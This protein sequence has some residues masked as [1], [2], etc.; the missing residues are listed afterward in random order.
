MPSVRGP[1]LMNNPHPGGGKVRCWRG[2]RLDGLSALACAR[3]PSTVHERFAREQQSTDY[4]RARQQR[5]AHFSRL[6]SAAAKCF[7]VGDAVAERVQALGSCATRARTG[8]GPSACSAWM[9]R[10][11]LP[12]R[13]HGGADCATNHH[14]QPHGEAFPAAQQPPQPPSPAHSGRGTTDDQACGACACASTIQLRASAAAP[15]APLPAVS[16]R[17]CWKM[18]RV[19]RSK[20]TTSA[21]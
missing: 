2:L 21:R 13:I 12:F 9:P 10:G 1:S 18:P 20:A 5:P 15:T 14:D 11:S 4:I 16:R 17:A 6:H 19:P 7:A 8:R 3:S